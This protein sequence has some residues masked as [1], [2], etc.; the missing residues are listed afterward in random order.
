MG[1]G[2]ECDDGNTEDGDG[3]SAECRMEVNLVLGSQFCTLSQG[4]WGSADGPA[5][6]PDGF[7]T[8]NPEILPVTIGG[9]GQL[10]TIAT[11]EALIAYLPKGGK[12][13]ALFPGERAFSTSGDVVED[14]GGSL[15]GQ[16]VAL[17]LAVNLSEREA[18]FPDFAD[19]ILPR[20]PFC[21]QGLLPGDDGLPGTEDD[22]LDP[23][24]PVTGPW[25]LPNTVAVANNTVSDLLIIANQY[26]RGES[27]TAAIS[28]VNEALDTLNRAFDSCRRV[29]ECP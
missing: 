16:T 1:E 6:G 7:V 28:E 26:L 5:N 24:S 18:T 21:T 15:A 19:L 14:G 3:C 8:R 12:P 2:E 10:T 17:A 25:H 23:A 9:P 27:N 20:T 22:Q 4:G 29:V 11:Q 13:R